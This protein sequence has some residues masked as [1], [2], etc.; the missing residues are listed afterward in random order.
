MT[1]KEEEF[2]KKIKNTLSDE[3]KITD[4]VMMD[5]IKEYKFTEKAAP[6][7]TDVGDVSFV[8]PT[9]QINTSCWVLGTAG[10]SW[11]V[12]A[13]GKCGYLHNA[14]ILAGKVMALSALELFENNEIIVKAKEELKERLNGEEYIC[15]IPSYIKPHLTVK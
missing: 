7:S 4:K 2:A 1:K 12:V 13:Q 14:M 5:S 15:P 10:H 6:G 9:A 11:Q 3:E 8:V